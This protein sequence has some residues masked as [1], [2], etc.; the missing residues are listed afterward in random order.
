MR[1][2]LIVAGV[3]AS[4]ALLTAPAMAGWKFEQV[5]KID[6]PGSSGHNDIVTYD[7]I[8][9]LLYISMPGDGLCVVDTRANSVYQ[10]VVN[11]PSLN[12][13]T[14]DKNYV[15][16]AA[17][18]GTPS[19][20][21]ND[22]GVAPGKI[23]DILVVSKEKWQVV[24]RVKT[25]GTTPDGIQI[26]TKNHFLYIQSDDNNWVEKYTTGKNPKFVA[27]WPLYP[28]D[29]VAGPD[30]GTVVPEL[31]A[32]FVPD[33]AWYLKLD[34]NTGEIVGK[35]DTGVKLSKHGGTKASIY[36]PKTG[37][38]WVGTTFAKSGMVI[39]DAKTMQIV[40][41]LPTHGG[42][43]AVAYD[44]KLGL[45]YAWGGGGRKGFDVFDMKTMTPVT[46]ISTGVGN[47]HAGDVD[48][49]THDVYTVSGDGSVVFVYR[50]VQN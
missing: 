45:L 20:A 31:N 17:G 50:P 42:I 7:P 13:N 8:A 46:F 3:L 28:E 37:Y 41:R 49:D 9:Q 29:P 14:F 38:M 32:L 43:D 44:P 11:M 26:D 15:Y 4:T 10:Y 16:A 19:G 1:R 30:V 27:K 5:A 23:N 39:V 33:D 47:T 22:D 35:L 24:G 40:K 18:D 48:T 6:L 21:P 36:D 34:T 2:G 25:Q 12:G